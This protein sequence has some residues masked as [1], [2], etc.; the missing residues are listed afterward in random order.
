MP[1]MGL[2]DGRALLAFRPVAALAINVL[3]DL[4]AAQPY[5]VATL[6]ALSHAGAAS[7]LDLVVRVVPTDEIDDALIADPGPGV[8]VG[9]GTPYRSPELVH[10]VIR[11]ARER[12]VP[13]VGT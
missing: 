5:R 10:E 6:D 3:I 13:L 7:Q 11:S 8:V 1:K 9:P 4:P 12:G 2:A